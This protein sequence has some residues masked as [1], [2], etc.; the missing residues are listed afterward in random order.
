MPVVVAD[1]VRRD[2]PIYLEGLGSVAAFYTVT[3]HSRVDGELERVAFEEGQTVH[4]GDLL[5][6]IDPR[7][8]EIQL[9]MAEANLAR[10]KAQLKDNKINY[11]RYVDLRKQDLIAQQQV[12]DQLAL[13]GQAE[14]TVKGDE[15]AVENAKL[16]LVYSR[17]TSPIDGVTGVRLVDPGNIVHAADTTGIVVIAQLDPIAVFVTL[18]EDDLG[19]IARQM[20]KGPLSARAFSRDEKIDYGSGQVALIDNQINQATGTLRLKVLFPNP[21]HV[22]W[23]NQFVKVRVLL[24]TRKDAIVVATSVVQHGPQGSFAY[25]VKSDQTVEARTIKVGPV[26]GDQ[27]LIEGGLEAGEVVV[28]DGQYKLRPGSRVTFKPAEASKPAADAGQSTAQVNDPPPDAG[29]PSAAADPKAK[30]KKTGGP[31][32]DP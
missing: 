16:Q 6:Q 23:P 11:D 5:V 24:S 2:F 17:I 28:T 3:L 27:T 4:K 12:D 13:V 25:V 9:H 15:A 7:P 1:V 29:N 8:Y 21:D 20:A 31:A 18:P 10:D 14:G 26:Q 22:L 32:L 30:K 19:E